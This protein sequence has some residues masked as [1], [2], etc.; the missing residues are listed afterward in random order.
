L[1]ALQDSLYGGGWE[2]YQYHSHQQAEGVCLYEPYPHAA[3]H[4]RESV[5]VDSEQ[6]I[7]VVSIEGEAVGLV[8]ANHDGTIE[9]AVHDGNHNQVIEEGEVIDVS[10]EQ[11]QMSTLEDQ[12]VAQQQQEQMQQEDT[13]AYN[14]GDDQSDYT[15]D[16]DPQFA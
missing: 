15:N 11:I 5:G 1:T 2:L 3:V 7:A 16:V 8:D 12:C 10:S 14:A 9:Y 6:G 4:L 13:F